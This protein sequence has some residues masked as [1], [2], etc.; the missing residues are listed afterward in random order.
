[1][2]AKPEMEA[3]AG[4]RNR[5]K[6]VTRT[7]LPVASV[8][9]S[10]RRFIPPK[11][12]EK[13]EGKWYLVVMAV[14]VVVAVV[15]GSLRKAGVEKLGRPRGQDGNAAAGSRRESNRVP[16]GRKVKWKPKATKDPVIDSKRFGKNR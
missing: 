13:G 10:R 11:K 5:R 14:A 4:T 12:E 16:M 7:S 2:E 8:A 1:M 3:E 9:K 6:E 15:V